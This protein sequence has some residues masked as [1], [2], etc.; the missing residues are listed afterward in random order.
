MMQLDYNKYD[1]GV[2]K[3]RYERHHLQQLVFVLAP[4]LFQHRPHQPGNQQFACG[5]VQRAML[6]NKFPWLRVADISE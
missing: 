5:K 3:L 1:Y 6:R 4:R 2:T